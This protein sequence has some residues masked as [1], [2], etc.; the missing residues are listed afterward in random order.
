MRSTRSIN[1]LKMTTDVLLLCVPVPIYSCILQT[2]LNT[3]VALGVRDDY[4]YVFFDPFG[5]GHLLLWILFFLLGCLIFC[6]FIISGTFVGGV[7]KVFTCLW[8]LDLLGI[9]IFLL[10]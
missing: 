9:S 6:T 3:Y 4:A 8:I 10:S 2:N 1:L 5:V 7:W